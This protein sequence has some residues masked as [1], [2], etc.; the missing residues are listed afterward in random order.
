MACAASCATISIPGMGQV[1]S[2]QDDKGT[3]I[4]VFKEWS[5][6]G[7][8]EQT[9]GIGPLKLGHVAF[10]TPD[11]QRTVAF[12]EKVLGF[13]VSDWIGDFFCFMRCNPDHHTVNF[14]T[15]P[16]AKL[17]HI[18]FELKDF[19]H[20]QNSC[21]L[22][23]QKKVP[24]IWGPLRHGPGHNVATYHRDHDAQVVEFFCE[25]DQMKDEDLG[26]FEPRPWHHDTP[27]RP[28]RW[29][30]G[31]TSVWGPIS[32]GWL[33]PHAV[34]GFA[35]LDHSTAARPASRSACRARATSGRARDRHIPARPSRKSRPASRTRQLRRRRCSEPSALPLQAVERIAGRMGLGYR[36]A[37]EPSVPIVVVALRAGEI[38]LALAAVNIVAAGVE[39]RPGALVDRDVDRHAA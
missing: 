27:Q 20:L 36:V 2:F 34:M 29:I 5:Y 22:M 26:Y 1:L 25:L 39:E 11:I 17:H 37:G 31:E 33:P 7:K 9:A 14:F 13:R 28:K 12:Y 35:S 32:R 15:G 6:L 19:M 3:T 8:H 21:E 18:A 10:Y 4:E 24:I 23:G 16:D 38:E 30:P